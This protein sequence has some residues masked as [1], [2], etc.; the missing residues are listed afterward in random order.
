MRAPRLLFGA[1][2]VAIA[3]SAQQNAVPIGPGV[4]PP[5]LLSKIEP[6]YSFEA[7]DAHVQGTV[8]FQIIVDEQGRPADISV[9]SPLAFG[10]DERAQA[11]IEKW[12]FLP[13]SKEGKP[14]RI[15]ATGEV[16][17]HLPG[18]WFDE[19]AESRRTK[20]NL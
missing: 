10:L 5:R 17:F 1:L 20:F 4:T 16:N 13:G 2:A 11:A 7:R 3:A 12:R 19:K 8:V 9:L 6:E 15:L 14:V 18:S